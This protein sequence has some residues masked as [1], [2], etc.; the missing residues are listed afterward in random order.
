MLGVEI[1]YPL[2][3]L[4]DDILSRIDISAFI[5]GLG[6]VYILYFIRLFLSRNERVELLLGTEGEVSDTNADGVE[7]ELRQEINT[8]K[9]ISRDDVEEITVKSSDKKGKITL[10]AKIKSGEEYVFNVEEN[11]A[12]ELIHNTIQEQGEAH[13]ADLDRGEPNDG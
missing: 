12:Q 11:V 8:R 2:Q 5:L 7:T 13:R 4:I 6:T 1:I 10:V 3:F 9:R